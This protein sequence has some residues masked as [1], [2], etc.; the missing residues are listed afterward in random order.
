[1]SSNEYALLAQIYEPLV[2]YHYLRRPYELIPLTATAVPEPNYFDKNMRPLP[3]GVAPEKVHR[4]VYDIKIQE[5]IK[6]QPHPAFALAKNGT[7]LYKKLTE[8]DLRG[9]S[10]I[11]HFKETGTRELTSDDY[12][13]EIKRLADPSLHSPILPI[14]T[15]YIL[16]LGELATALKTDLAEIRKSRKEEQGAAYNQSVDE[17]ENPIILDYSK[18]PFPGV[19]RIDG[20]SFQIIL[21]TKYPQFIYWLAMPFFSPIPEEAV[22]FYKQTPLITRNI[23]IDRFPVGTGAFMMET[24]NPNMEMVLKKN[25]LFH[26]EEFPSTGEAGDKEAGLLVDAGEPLPFLDKVVFKLEKEAIPRWNKFLQGYYD[27]SGIASD[28]FDQAVTISAEGSADITDTMRE[29]GIRL[30]TS[31]RPSIY[32][33]GFNML[34]DVVGGY[35]E[36]AQKLRQAITIALDQEEFIEIFNNGRGIPAMGPLPPGIFGY[37]EGKDGIN[38]YTYNWDEA[39]KRPTRKSLKEAKRLLAEAGYPEGRDSDGRPLVIS[40][41][42]TFTDAGSQAMLGWYSKRFK[43]IGIELQNKATDYNR[44]QEKMHKGNFQFFFWGWN[45]DYPDPENF[46]FLL[47]E[48]NGKVKH[49]GENAANYANPDFDRLFKKM[50]NMDSG[51]ERLKIINKMTR[52]AQKDAPWVWGYYPVDFALQNSWVKKTK[53]NTMANNTMKYLKI[54]ALE[55]ARL[56]KERNRPK[57]LPILIALIIFIACAVPAAIVVKRKLG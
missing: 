47:T 20:Q 29:K 8:A 38:P 34:D 49:Q 32:Y 55:R 31:V 17:K 15:K 33:M 30:V 46:F 24:F 2:Q 42:N 41:D 1:Y 18:H 9:I 26:G 7:P 14:L 21:K 52:I 19:K 13:Y 25:P 11:K 40:F 4:A 5:G 37:T 54:D 51:P 45:A 57:L 6:Y 23:T 36:R 44:F 43:L 39:E 35:S 27:A 53:S 3:R 50:E 22:E 56:R 28:S 16:G 48:G 12:I 10:E